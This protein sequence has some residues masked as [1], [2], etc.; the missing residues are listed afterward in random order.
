MTPRIVKG[1]TS[2][3]M[4]D[5]VHELRQPLSAIE[6][7]AYYLEITSPDEK[8][9]AQVERIQAMISQ[10]NRILQAKSPS[11]SRELL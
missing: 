5:L 6:C 10:A 11:L 3:P 4:E 1:A 9:R 8:V 7:I 2:T